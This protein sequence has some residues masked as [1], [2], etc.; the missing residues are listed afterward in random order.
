M[1]KWVSSI[2]KKKN[3]PNWSPHTETE[4]STNTKSRNPKQDKGPRFNHQ[5]STTHTLKSHLSLYFCGTHK[6]PLSLSLFLKNLRDDSARVQNE[7]Q[8]Q[9]SLSLCCR[10]RSPSSIRQCR[11]VSLRISIPIL[12]QS[13]SIFQFPCVVQFFWIRFWKTLEFFVCLFVSFSISSVRVSKL[14][15]L[16]SLI[17]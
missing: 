4:T 12:L 17:S 6:L 7:T 9:L 16:V 8:N 11:Y 1:K 3:V 5:S 14:T 13:S 2:F 10:I 15:E